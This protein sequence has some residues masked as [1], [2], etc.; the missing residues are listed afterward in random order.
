MKHKYTKYTKEIIE[1][2]TNKSG[3][4]T[5]SLEKLGLKITGGNYTNLKRNIVKFNVDVSHMSKETYRKRKVYKTPASQYLT[6]NST[7]STGLPVNGDR[8]KKKLFKEGIKEKRCEVCNLTEWNGKDIS[9]ELHHINGIRVDNRLENIQILCPNC[10]S[11]TN[12]YGIRNRSVPK[13]V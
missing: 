1:A 13:G 11:Q 8:L 7:Y 2:A 10:H 5:E 6:E 9:L 3:S 4:Y 12:N